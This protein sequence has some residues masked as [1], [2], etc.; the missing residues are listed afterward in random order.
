MGGKP[1]DTQAKRVLATPE[2]VMCRGALLRARVAGRV[3]LGGL[4]LGCLLLGCLL[5]SLVPLSALAAEDSMQVAQASPERSIWA[6]REANGVRPDWEKSPVDAHLPPP[7][8][9]LL[10][11]QLLWG[12]QWPLDLVVPQIYTGPHYRMGLGAR[13]EV[14]QG[15]DAAVSLGYMGHDG[16][17]I[18]EETHVTTGDATYLTLIPVELGASYRPGVLAQGHVIPYVA[19]GLDFTYY[20]EKINTLRYYGLKPG[21]HLKAGVELPLD[22]PAPTWTTDARSGMRSTALVLELGYAGR[23]GF[24]AGGLDLSTLAFNLGFSLGF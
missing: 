5:W 2:R 18:G 19:A 10:R 9:I 13:Y 23:N 20:R 11:M 21:Y 24:G 15:L 4:L 12:P 22:P 17:A 1:A 8:P 6:E 14:F 7:V 3:L 16:V